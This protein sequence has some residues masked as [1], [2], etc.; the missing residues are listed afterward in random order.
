MQP[1]ADIRIIDFSQRLPGSYCSSILADLGANVVWV[2][3]AGDFP[4]TRNVFPGLLE[5]VSRNKRSMTLNLKSDEGKKIA[6]RLTS[7][8]DVVIEEFRPGVAGRLG[9]GYDQVK[10]LNPGVVYCS[11]SGFG[12]EGPYR[13][14]AGHDINYLSLSG[15]LS[16][17]G[18]PDTPPS[19][20]GVPLVD[21]TAGMFAAISVMGAIRKRDREGTGD[22]IDISMLDCMV[23]W[24]STRAGRYLVYGEKTENEHLSALNNI[25]ETKDGKKVSLGILEQH[26]WENFCKALG[27]EELL[28]DPRFTTAPGRK[29][30]LAQ[31]LIVLREI[32][33]Q[34]TSD[35]LGRML[36]WIQVPFAP[37]LSMEEALN[38]SH[39]RARNLI[40]EI[41]V[42]GL[43]RIKEVVFPALFSGVRVEIKTPPPRWGE[44]TEAILREMG[45]TREEISLFKE[46][47]AI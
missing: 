18:Q 42:E 23:S 45:Y 32:I 30:N 39:A 7:H 11:V 41:D 21:L 25:Y 27:K 15:I 22:Y 5:L 44:H 29:K 38:D 2:E 37:V 24:M 46:K 28:K 6:G 1:F 20:P 34:Y 16:I 4:E 43:G 13:E 36:D 14:R 35:E 17:P 31:L 12:Q 3:R 19:R 9:I 8:C 40:Q 33:S 26:F 47:A 10:E